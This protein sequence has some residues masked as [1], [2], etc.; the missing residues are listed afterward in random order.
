MDNWVNRYAS[1]YGRK[2][3]FITFAGS[4]E[5]SFAEKQWK[6]LFYRAEAQEK[7]LSLY[8]GSSCRCTQSNKRIFVPKH[9]NKDE[10][11]ADAHRT[12]KD[13]SADAQEI[14]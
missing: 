4:Q 5:H 12:Q 13:F 6:R 7:T 8:Q 14:S 9:S 1:M 2:S 11:S 10:F 3:L